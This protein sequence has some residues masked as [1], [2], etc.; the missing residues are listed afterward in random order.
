MITP[1]ITPPVP[2]LLSAPMAAAY[3]SIGM[4]TF[5]HRWRAHLLPAPHRIGRRLLW[6]RKMLDAFVDALSELEPT[7]VPPKRKMAWD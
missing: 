6:D 3:L 2:R 7:V 4:R 5:E 1:L